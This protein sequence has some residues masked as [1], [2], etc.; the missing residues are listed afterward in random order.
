MSNQ[1]LGRAAPGPSPLGPDL[2]SFVYIPVKSRCS[3]LLC[4]VLERVVGYGFKLRLG[5][6]ASGR[7]CTFARA[8][9]RE[10]PDLR[11]YNYKAVA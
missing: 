8:E 1:R 2:S 11:D 4:L 3:L 5:P 6:R 10:T 9:W 7:R